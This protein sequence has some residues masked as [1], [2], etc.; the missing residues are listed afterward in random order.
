MNPTIISIRTV[1]VPELTVADDDAPPL[2]GG[3]TVP[4]H[5]E[6]IVEVEGFGWNRR[7]T[8]LRFRPDG[9]PSYGY[10]AIDP[11]NPAEVEKYILCAHREDCEEEPM[12]ESGPDD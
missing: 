5:T 11:R 4:A 8:V 1:E 6:A 12:A 2:L 9:E 7:R 10:F 3:F